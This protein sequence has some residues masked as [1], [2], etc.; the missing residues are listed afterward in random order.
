MHSTAIDEKTGTALDK[1]LRGIEVTIPLILE[2]PLSI[3]GES[4]WPWQEYLNMALPLLRH[5]GSKRNRGMGRVIVTLG[6]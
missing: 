4:D 5:V 6:A 2:A 3:Q 1:S